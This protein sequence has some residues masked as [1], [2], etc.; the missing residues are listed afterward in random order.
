[1]K[2]MREPQIIPT[3]V[4][5]DAADLAAGAGK[6]GTFAQSIHLDVNDGVFTPYVTWPYR[7]HGFFDEFDM[8]GAAGLE[9]EVHLMVEEPRRVGIAFARAGAFRILGHVEGFADTGEAHGALDAWRG[10][11]ASEVGLALLLETPLP[12][13]EPLVRACDFLHLMTI[14]AIGV[15]GIPYDPR[16]PERVAHVRKR[17]PELPISVDG[18]VS[19]ENIAQLRRAGASRFGVGSAIMKASDPAAAYAR[20]KKIAEDAI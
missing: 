15:Q 11:G 1:M 18:G 19:A 20:I 10:A 12:V 7:S 2:R 14:A 5:K 4:P 13:V 3:Y 8:G 6:I 16:A 9:S 17:F